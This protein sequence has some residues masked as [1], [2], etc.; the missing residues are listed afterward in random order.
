[1][2]SAPEWGWIDNHPIVRV[3]WNDAKEYC[4]WLSRKTGKNFRLPTEAEWEYAARGETTG[5]YPA[6][7]DR[8]A[9]YDQN[10]GRQTHPVGQREPNA[11]GLYD[12]LGNVW[13]WVGDWYNEQ[14]YAASPDVDPRGPSMDLFRSLRGGSWLNLA[15]NIRVSIRVGDDPAFRSNSVGFRCVREVVP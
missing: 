2:A 7:P 10:S 14:Y 3:T 8:T 11:W 12:M 9:W 5:A 4:K 15:A 6:A 13:E 1:M